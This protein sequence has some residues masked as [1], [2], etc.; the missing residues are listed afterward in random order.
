[1]DIEGSEY[2]VI[3]NMPQPLLRQFRVMVIEFHFLDKIFSRFGCLLLENVFT[4]ILEDFYVVHLHPNNCCGSV[5]Q[6]GI[7]IP[8][9]MEFTFLRKDRAR[10]TLPNR[11]FP[12]PLDG[13][14][15]PFNPPLNLP[16]C[17]YQ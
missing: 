8:R 11:R 15:I 3:M 1:M 14:N 17:W 2:E 10:Q 4:K 12:H 5:T 16:G 13:K 9:V 7:E 6:H